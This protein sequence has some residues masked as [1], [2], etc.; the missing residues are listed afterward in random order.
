M[1]VLVVSSPL[2]GHLSPLLPVMGALVDAG[3]EVRDA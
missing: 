3:D 2:A 1:K